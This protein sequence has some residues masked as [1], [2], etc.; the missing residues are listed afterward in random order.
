MLRA[1]GSVGLWWELAATNVLLHARL[2]KVQWLQG[3]DGMCSLSKRLP[4][5]YLP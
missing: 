5:D 4:W 2:S 3:V 1:G